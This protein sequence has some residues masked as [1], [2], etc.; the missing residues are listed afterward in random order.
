MPEALPQF[1]PPQT[2]ADAVVICLHGFT[3]T[4]YEI[5]P[6]AKAIALLGLPTVAPLLPG[7][8]YKERSQQEKQFA[9][10]TMADMLGAARLEIARARKH[11]R[12]VGMFGLSMGGAIALSMAGLGLIDV[13]AVAAPALRL[14]KLA[15][16]LIPLLSW[17][18][19]TLEVPLTEPFYVPLYEFYHSKALRTL[20]Q[21][22]SHAREHL[23]QIQCPVLGVHSHQDLL[24]PPVVLELMQK[25]IPLPIETAWF[26]DS[27]HSM[28]LDNSGEE[29]ASTIAEFFALKLMNK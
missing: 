19:F 13:C 5:E 29:V 2:G 21:L 8:G 4:P 3:S 18:D 14:P 12:Y 20:W 1:F 6:A 23:S 9:Q 10:I 25:D 17:A 22:A 16:F 15:E 24:V 26:D 28:L 27:G 11:Y 7:H